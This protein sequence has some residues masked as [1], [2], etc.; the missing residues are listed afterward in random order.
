M[1][2]K[3]SENKQKYMLR[4]LLVVHGASVLGGRG[5]HLAGTAGGG[6]HRPGSGQGLVGEA[7]VGR[8]DHRLGP[9]RDLVACEVVQPLLLAQGALQL[10]LEDSGGRLA[11]L[12]EVSLDKEGLHRI[13]L[14][15]HHLAGC[16][17]CKANSSA[18]AKAE[19]ERETRPA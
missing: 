10:L 7:L 19:S 2:G 6:A 13:Q 4:R 12:V 14:A 15:Q 11:V 8:S 17:I 5:R 3:E 16:I 9:L 1:V 18:A